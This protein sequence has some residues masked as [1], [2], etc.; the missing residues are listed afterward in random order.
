MQRS[1]GFI[2]H[3]AGLFH[4]KLVQQTMDDGCE[5]DAHDC[6]EN[7]TTKKRIARREELSASSPWED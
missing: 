6:Y 7:Q 4:M 3:P 5:H 2:L 1:T